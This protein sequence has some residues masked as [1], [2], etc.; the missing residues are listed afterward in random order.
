MSLQIVSKKKVAMQFMAVLLT[1]LAARQSTAGRAEGDVS[2][3]DSTPGVAYPQF[4]IQEY[5]VSVA[6]LRAPKT[7]QKNLEQAKKAI[8]KNRLPEAERFLKSAVAVYPQYAEAWFDL[9]LIYEDRQQLDKAADAY[10]EAVRADAMDI[11]SYRNLMAIDYTQ[12]NWRE[13]AGIS[14]K[15]IVIDPAAGSETYFVSAHAHFHTGELGLSEKRAREG[16]RSDTS[17]RFPQFYLILANISFVRQDADSSA[18]YLQSY[19]D[20]APNASN[21]GMARSYLQKLQQG[22]PVTETN[23]VGQ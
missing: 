18:R 2:R 19:L 21:A 6:N 3:M 22:V 1:L 11:R 13:A 17:H 7:A 9:G 4:Q 14:E 15:L 10:R 16:L 23:A 20:L 8:L 12:R 5:R